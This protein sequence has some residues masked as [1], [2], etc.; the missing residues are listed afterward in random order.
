V[1]LAIGHERA[2]AAASIRFSIGKDTTEAEVDYAV[3]TLDRVIRRMMK[4]A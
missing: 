1:L 2:T 4:R 3:D